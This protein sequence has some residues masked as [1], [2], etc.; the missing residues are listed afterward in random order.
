MADLLIENGFRYG[1]VSVYEQV[2]INQWGGIG[3]PGLSNVRNE[4]RW[5]IGS[6]QN[7]LASFSGYQLSQAEQVVQFVNWVKTICP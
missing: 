5:F 2:A 1:N 4:V 6:P 7:T 3:S